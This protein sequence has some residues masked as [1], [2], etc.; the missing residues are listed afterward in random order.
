[1][2]ANIIGIRIKLL[3]EERQ[4]TMEKLASDL[5]R[6]YDVRINKGMISKWESGGDMITLANAKL[7]CLYFDESLDFIV[8]L[9]DTRKREP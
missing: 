4:L 8:G 3:R 6:L 1:M 2:K 5:C 7:I 9:S